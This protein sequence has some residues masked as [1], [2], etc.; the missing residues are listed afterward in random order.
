M[1]DTRFGLLPTMIGSLPHTSARTACELVAK[2]L[3]EIPCWPQLPRR[4]FRE[5]MYV[6]FSEGLPGVVIEEDEKR[7]YVDPS[8]ISDRD[9]ERLYI[10]YL[11]NNVDRFPVSR[12]YAEGL[13]EFLAQNSISPI[14]VKGQ[15]TGPVSFGLTVKDR[16]GQPLIYDENLADLT[17]KLLRLKA[18]WQERELAK[19]FKN[20]IVFVD[21]PYLVSL[22]SAYVVISKEKAQKLLEEVF[23]G[24][25]GLKGIHCCGNTDWQ[26]LLSTSTDILS[27]DAYNYAQPFSLYPAEVGKFIQR[28]GAVAW[29]IVPNGE[30]ELKRETVSSLKDRLEE[31][32]APFTR[33]GIRFESL[34]EHGLLT[35]SCGLA[36]LSEEAAETALRLL[37]ELSVVMRKAYVR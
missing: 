7:I 25:R 4:T 11:E 17:A 5:N 29:G 8:G 13:Y 23:G 22:G 27:F 35:P 6:Q 26:L 12:E 2:Y 21:E 20:T 10:T 31:A 19:V 9:M 34:A 30:D 32:I 1:P 24:I 18:G 33:K 28:G 14:A 15:V 16:R 36:T 3:K 37:A